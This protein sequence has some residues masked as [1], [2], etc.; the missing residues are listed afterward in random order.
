MGIASVILAGISL[1]NFVLEGIVAVTMIMSVPR[2]RLDYDY[3]PFNYLMGWW[4]VGSVLIAIC[5]IVFGIG[6][7]R[8][9]DRRHSAATWG[10]CLNIAIP[11]VVMFVALLGSA[12]SEQRNRGDFTTASPQAVADAP[13]R[14]P[15]ARICQVLTVGLLI[16][17]V[18]FYWTRRK[19][20]PQAS[21]SAAIG[22]IICPRCKKQ[23]P[24][25]S[26]FCR[27]CGNRLFE[28]A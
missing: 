15:T 14:S 24:K 3:S 7:I 28:N 17:T 13:W 18:T 10:L 20:R 11:F 16:G 23:V 27:R 4:T 6:G 12:L 19:M 1:V 22:A 2:D 26:Q 25:R 9:K 8:Q 21:P 5:G